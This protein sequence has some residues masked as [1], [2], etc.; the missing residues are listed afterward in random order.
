M[1]KKCNRELSDLGGMMKKGT[2]KLRKEKV[3]NFL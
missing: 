3:N 2:N 1:M